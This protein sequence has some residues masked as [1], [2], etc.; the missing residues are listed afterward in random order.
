MARCI[1]LMPLFSTDG[2]IMLFVTYWMIGLNTSV[3]QITYAIILSLLSNQAASAFGIAM[4]CIFPTAQVLSFILFNISISTLDDLGNG[5]S[6]AR[7]VSSYTSM[8][9]YAFEGHVVNQWSSIDEFH[10]E[11]RAT[12]TDATRD[13]VLDGF[14][15][16]ADAIPWDIL[17]LIVN[18]IVFYLIGFGALLFRMKKAR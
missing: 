14:S 17:G 15:F 18:C 4:S 13:S 6:T 3:G 16:S 1:S 2:L 5:E 9:R 7:P 11:A 8:Y 12:W 10:P